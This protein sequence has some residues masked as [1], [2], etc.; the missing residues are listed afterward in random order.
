MYKFSTDQTT[1]FSF[2][3]FSILIKI[4]IISQF[5]KF[6]IVETSFFGP[7]NFFKC[8][9]GTKIY[10]LCSFL[11]LM[12]FTNFAFKPSLGSINFLFIK[13]L[14]YRETNGI[15]NYLKF[16]KFLSVFVNDFFRVK[17][18]EIYFFLFKILSSIKKNQ[19]LKSYPLNYLLRLRKINSNLDSIE[20]IIFKISEM[21]Q[22]NFSLKFFIDI[23]KPTICSFCKIL[24]LL[25]KSSLNPKRQNFLS[26]VFLNKI[27]NRKHK[28]IFLL[29]KTKFGIINLFF[30]KKNNLIFFKNQKKKKKLKFYNEISKLDLLIFEKIFFFE[31]GKIATL[32]FFEEYHDFFYSMEKRVKKFKFIIIKDKIE[33]IEELSSKVSGD[34]ESTLI[35]T[36]NCEKFKFIK[37]HQFLVFDKFLLEKFNN[38]LIIKSRNNNKK[39][40]QLFTIEKLRRIFRK[41]RYYKKRNFIC[42]NYME[43]V[44]KLFW[45]KSKFFISFFNPLKLFLKKFFRTRKKLKD[46]ETIYFTKINKP[47]EYNQFRLKNFSFSLNYFSKP[48][49]S[50]TWVLKSFFISQQDLFPKLRS[51][52]KNYLNL[53]KKLFVYSFLGKSEKPDPYSFYET[54]NKKIGCQ[55]LI[56]LK[57]HNFFDLFE[58]YKYFF[59]FYKIAKFI[60][61]RKDL[62]VEIFWKKKFQ[63]FSL[64]FWFIRSDNKVEFESKLKV[65]FF[66]YFKK[67]FS[68]GIYYLKK[69]R[70]KP[71]IQDRNYNHLLQIF[72]IKS[73]F[74]I[75]YG[76]L[77]ITPCK[78]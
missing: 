77:K 61:N 19:L 28:L 15:E 10:N 13:Y 23:F 9:L 69:K 55:F 70:I 65:I 67:S 3:A 53:F 36:F 68:L 45:S 71:K 62:P 4:L 63:F 72:S 31:L 16:E 52:L 29:K 44:Y 5:Y 73:F 17:N 40:Q 2:G 39:Q 60:S 78:N 76:N 24:T 6:V 64:L 14:I 51:Y 74:F 30:K 43:S 26:F 8:S 18:P 35:H 37:N 32:N 38:L 7:K 75:D 56:D 66:K 58:Q 49:I 22:Q 48:Y 21:F 25:R 33:F 1:P 20:I 50:W 46:L 34:A 11:N 59:G 12:F 41:F 27:C 47:F 54:K 42:Q 57:I